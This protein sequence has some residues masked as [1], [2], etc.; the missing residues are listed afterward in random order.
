MHLILNT[1]E[2]V[3]EIRLIFKNKLIF[4]LIPPQ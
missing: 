1:L 4:Q 3:D 2:N